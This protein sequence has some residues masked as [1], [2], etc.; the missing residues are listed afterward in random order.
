VQLTNLLKP[1]HVFL[2]I[3]ARTREEV[4]VYVAQRLEQAGTVR[5]SQDLVDLLLDRERLGATLVG[6]ETAIPHCKVPGLDG[7]IAAFARSPE[8]VPFGLDQGL[9]RLFFFILSPQEQPAAHL[10]VLANIARL[11]GNPQVRSAF[12]GATDPGALTSA[13]SDA[14]AHR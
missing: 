3:P 1:E 5:R 10:K 8:P 4:L 9:A 13:L 12:E 2:D 11:L 6:E 14:E 7:V